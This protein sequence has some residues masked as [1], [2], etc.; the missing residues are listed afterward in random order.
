MIPMLPI[1]THIDLVTELNSAR[2]TPDVQQVPTVSLAQQ[3]AK[4]L[5]DA[6]RSL[7]QRRPAPGKA[8]HGATAH[9]TPHT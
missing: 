3:L 7:R 9:N 2:R 5:V 4:R 8:I 6:L 1:Q